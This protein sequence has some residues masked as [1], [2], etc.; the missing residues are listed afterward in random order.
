M[1]CIN[2]NGRTYTRVFARV[3]A[4]I[5]GS[6]GTDECAKNTF[7]RNTPGSKECDACDASCHPDD[8]CTAAGP[9]GCAEG[10]CAD[11]YVQSRRNALLRS[12]K[13]GFFLVE[14][15]CDWQSQL[16]LFS[17]CL[18]LFP[19]M[20]TANTLPPTERQYR[21]VRVLFSAHRCLCQGAVGRG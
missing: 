15:S 5:A 6:L 21:L 13:M 4:N 3:G 11:G 7:C 17:L 1:L 8:G 2:A 19:W 18:L 12:T 10:T 9:T 20:V 16:G 14:L